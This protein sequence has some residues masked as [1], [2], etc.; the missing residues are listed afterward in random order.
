MRALGALGATLAVIATMLPWYSFDVIYSVRG[1]ASVFAVPVSLWGLTTVAPILITVGAV[2]ALLCLA[3]IS[4]RVA[5][6]VTG[7]VGAG[8][9][10][11]AIYRSV[12]VPNLGHPRVGPIRAA[13]VLESGAIFAIAAGGML[14]ISG[15]ADVLLPESDVAEPGMTAVADEGVPFHPAE[16]AGVE[17]GARA[18]QTPDR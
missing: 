18:G 8:I 12:N 10:A 3:L 1:I 14:L 6:I 5:G 7:L 11:Y 17:A 2:L 13:T 9:L 4:S 16:P 15:I